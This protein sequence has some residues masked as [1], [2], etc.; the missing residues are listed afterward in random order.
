MPIAKPNQTGALNLLQRSWPATLNSSEGKGRPATCSRTNRW[1]AA[2]NES[3]RLHRELP[4]LSGDRHVK[5]PIFSICTA[6]AHSPM[7]NGFAGQ[8]QGERIATASRAL[9]LFGG[10]ISS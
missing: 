5:K 7:I 2:K 3:K 9:N 4:R 8:S 6:T 10:E 1:A